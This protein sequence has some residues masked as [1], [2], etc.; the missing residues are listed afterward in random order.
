MSCA[1]FTAPGAGALESSSSARNDAAKRLGPD[2][3]AAIA[4]DPPPAPGCAPSKDAVRMVSPPGPLDR[5][6]HVRRRHGPQVTS[7][8]FDRL[9]VALVQKLAALRYQTW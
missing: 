2:S 5:G 6:C 7:S 8:P 1:P 3:L 4:Q 9:K